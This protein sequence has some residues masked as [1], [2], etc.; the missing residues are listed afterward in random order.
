MRIRDI[1][2]KNNALASI[3][4]FLVFAYLLVPG[5]LAAGENSQLKLEN[6]L[7]ITLYS[8]EDI[9]AMSVRDADGLLW[10]PLPNGA[11]Y[12]LIEDVLDSEIVNKGDGSFH[13]VNED[14]VV[15]ALAKIDIPGA[16]LKM[17]VNV[18]VLPMPRSGFLASSACG[19]CIFLSPGVYEVG[20]CAVA[21]TATHELGHVFQRCFAPEGNG[22][23]WPEYLGIRGIGDT[24]IYSADAAHMNRPIEIFAEDFRYL[25][26][27]SEACSS[28]KIENCDI[29][30][31][32]EVTGLREFFIALAEP[33]EYA[34]SAPL[35]GSLFALSNYPNPFNPSTTIRVSFSRSA[36][37][38]GAA[39]DLSIYRIDGSLVRHLYRGAATGS[40]LSVRWDGRDAQGRAAPTGVYLIVA[41]SGAQRAAGKMLLMR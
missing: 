3:I 35:G 40:E 32:D 9:L 2:L 21:C 5:G 25:F 11:K 36:P 23:K 15:D 26:G 31:P 13:P 22:G 20:R 39:I 7:E 17:S 28:G 1:M 29:P 16:K 38:I 30:L 10:L 24:T 6:G 41:S 18:Y 4:I 37:E 27:G 12:R 34:L 33:A 19:D 14:W 8:S